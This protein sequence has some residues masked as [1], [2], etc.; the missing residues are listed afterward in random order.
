MEEIVGELSGA[1]VWSLLLVAWVVYLVPLVM[2]VIMQRREPVAT[3]SWVLSLALL[4]YVGFAI[5]YLLGP[6]R[7]RRRLLRRARGRAALDRRGR[8]EAVRRD[9]EARQLALLAENAGGFPPSTC[10][11]AQLLVDGVATYD[12]L[13][14][15][16][17][18]AEHHIHL[19]YYIYRPDRIGTRLRD[20]LIRQAKRGV[21]VRL[22]VDAVGGARLRRS[23]LRP[24]RRAGVEFSWFHETRW[25]RLLLRRPK[26]NLRTHRKIVVV[27]GRVGF[28]G[29]I[30]IDDCHDESLDCGRFHDFHLRVEGEAVRW[31]QLAFLEDWHYATRVALRD[32][33][34]WPEIE[35]GSIA[36]QVLAAGPDTHWEPIHRMQVE[37]IHASQCRV[38]LSTPY[39][40]PG[41]AGLFA[42]TS[43]AMRGLDVRLLVPMGRHSDSALVSAAARSYYDVL[44]EAGV[45]VFEYQPRMT[46]GK[47]L[48]VDDD[49]AIVGSSNFDPRSFR[50]NFEIAMW[51]HDCDFAARLA[52]ELEGDFAESL[53]IVADRA[54]GSFGQRFLDS[55]ARLLGPIL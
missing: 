9:A 27:D 54:R 3:L 21:R 28:T 17:E 39:F 8:L 10:A 36:C 29:G 1:E 12:A 15:A 24:L 18:A 16:I 32:E 2:W 33:R 35:P 5:Y 42:L 46:H 50:L 48:L 45:R 14:A 53:E 6:Q 25:A 40:V 23:F 34:L 44:L 7:V 13:L 55:C 20:A 26:L 49:E 51:F 30:N 47:A 11:S 19:E 52:E 38:W 37:L 43:A 22:L 31:L 41:E 4:P